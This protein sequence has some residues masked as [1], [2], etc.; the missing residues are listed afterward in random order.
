[1]PPGTFAVASSNEEEIFSSPD[2]RADAYPM[3]VRLADQG[4]PA[5][6]RLLAILKSDT[7]LTPPSRR[8]SVMHAVA[9]AFAI[10]GPRAHGALTEVDT[11]ISSNRSR[12]FGNSSESRAWEVAL[13]RMGK[14][15]EEFDWHSTKP[16]FVAKQRES[17]RRQVERFNPKDVW[18][19]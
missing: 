12:F 18:N 16:D 4:E 8:D 1:M 11:L 7:T 6:P 19:L 17:L 13:A 9:L 14:P 3:I 5:I 15:I 10:L 2:L